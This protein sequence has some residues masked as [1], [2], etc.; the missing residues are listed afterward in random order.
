MQFKKLA[1]AVAIATAA[2]AATSANA[3]FVI[4]G[5]S[6]AGGYNPGAFT[7]LPNSIVSGLT[8]YSIDPA[9]IAVGSTGNFVG[10]VGGLAV[11]NSFT[12]GTTPVVMFTDGGFTFTILSF[13][14][15]AIIPFACIGAQCTDTIGFSG[16]GQVSGNG[17]QTTGFTMSWSSQ[18]A[19]NESASVPNT[20]APGATASWSASVAATGSEPTKVPEPTSLALVG[21]ALAG[22]G[23]TARRR[24]AK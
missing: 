21:L 5:T 10:F 22:V 17:F 20:C 16:V 13:G 11:S 23:F 3:A 14:P 24:A 7:N 4:G 15:A 18:G 12:F 9:S 8:S 1:T 2:L 6:F 19:C